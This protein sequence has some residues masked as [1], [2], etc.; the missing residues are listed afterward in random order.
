CMPMPIEMVTDQS[1]DDSPEKSPITEAIKN[2]DMIQERRSVAMSYMVTVVHFFEVDEAR[3]DLV[4]SRFGRTE[5]ARIQKALDLSSRKVSS[6]LV[7]AEDLPRATY[8]L[9]ENTI[10]A[11]P[12]LLDDHRRNGH[13]PDSG[14]VY[15]D[16]DK[17]S[18]L[19]CISVALPFELQIGPEIFPWIVGDDSD[20][21]VADDVAAILRYHQL[22][23]Y[24]RY[25]WKSFSV[26]KPL[27]ALIFSTFRRLSF[28]NISASPPT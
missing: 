10:G 7:I 6:R 9:L 13:G 4:D 23:N 15:L 25:D 1:R 14:R 19:S 3:I 16:V 20:R 22:V 17:A 21:V 24:L 18:R 2:T 8:D 26:A 28:Q 12:Y 11:D 27:P 5:L